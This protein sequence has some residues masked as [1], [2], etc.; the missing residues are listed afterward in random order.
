MKKSIYVVLI[1]SVFYSCS[2]TEEKNQLTSDP[3]NRNVTLDFNTPG[4]IHNEALDWVS[5]N[6]S[7]DQSLTHEAKVDEIQ[8]KFIDYFNQSN[9]ATL[10]SQHDIEIAFQHS[11]EFYRT[12]T[13]FTN[14][15]YWVNVF[16]TIR[17]ILP[18][19][20]IQFMEKTIDLA[21]NANVNFVVENEIKIEKLYELKEEL[22][23]LKNEW[24][25]FTFNDKTNGKIS[26]VLISV[27]LHSSQFWIENF[28]NIEY[29]TDD[30]GTISAFHP[31]LV[32]AGGAALGIASGIIATG[33]EDD[34]T[35]EDY[36][37]NGLIGGLIGG[38]TTSVSSVLGIGKWVLK[39]WW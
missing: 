33:I 9:Y 35:W 39:L 26:G 30:D 21:M 10:F 1:L 13:D 7:F 38:F 3:Q 6:L 27:A 19:D 23:L 18:E 25:E 16:S 15:N 2:N 29:T 17:D 28:E 12:D 4:E 36:A 8:R 32:D 11:S 20:E 31:G 14:K 24:S 34:P 5:K 22:L 37:W